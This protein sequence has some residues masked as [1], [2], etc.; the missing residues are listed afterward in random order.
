MSKVLSSPTVSSSLPAA[1]HDL[2]VLSKSKDMLPSSAA[3]P[4]GQVARRNARER[5]RVRQVNM[6]FVTLRNHIPNSGKAKKLSKVE[7]LRSAACYIRY[8]KDLLTNSDGLCPQ[9]DQSSQEI[10][11]SLQSF[12]T[13]SFSTPNS[14]AS[15]P[16]YGFQPSSTPDPSNCCYED[17][18]FHSESSFLPH[19]QRFC[20][21]YP[22][23]DN[24]AKN[25]FSGL[26]LPKPP[27]SGS[28]SEGSS[29]GSFASEPGYEYATATAATT[30]VNAAPNS[31]PEQCQYGGQFS[32][33][34]PLY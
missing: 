13:C 22:S 30:N 31:L 2:P 11:Q 16:A 33:L 32:H 12:P 7:T 15:T 26:L 8:L 29:G 19:S 28:F 23:G 3:K 27:P 6:G 5:N 1:S 9:F 24:N 20:T 17:Y 10:L 4:P 18:S 14:A 25:T 21:P 34:M